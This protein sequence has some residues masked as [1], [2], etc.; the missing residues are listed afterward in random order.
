MAW[1]ELAR[2]TEELGSKLKDL[3]SFQ[4]CW[5]LISLWIPIWIMALASCSWTTCEYLIIIKTVIQHFTSMGVFAFA[6]L[7]SWRIDGDTM[8]LYG[9][10]RLVDNAIGE[11]RQI[12][13]AKGEQ[14]FKELMEH[15]T[16]MFAGSNNK[17]NVRRH[18]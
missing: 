7:N 18:G 12:T 16:K 10:E 9:A 15:L 14:Y 17:G 4:D 11:S 8:R 3:S 5:P 1:D 13:L 2:A 6:N